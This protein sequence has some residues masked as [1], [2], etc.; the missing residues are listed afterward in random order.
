MSNTLDIAKNLKQVTKS[1]TDLEAQYGRPPG[2]VSLLAVSKTKPVSAIQDAINAGQRQFGE[3]YL[4]E[5]IEKIHALKKEACQ[6]HFIGGIQSRKTQLIAEHFDWV[7]SVDRVKLINRLAT[8]R[9][10]QLQA[11]NVCLQV[12]LDHE[13]SKS[14]ALETDLAELANACN[15]HKSLRLRGLMA[16][17]APRTQLEE[18]REPFAR[19]AAM[20]NSLRKDHPSLDTLSMG[21]SSDLPAAIAEGATIVRVGTAIF[22]QR[23]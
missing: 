23:N 14:G 20:F 21:M 17:P 11:L 3:N 19:L 18:Q 12:N 13:Q 4:D 10:T 22:G 8:Q 1:I 5:A 6:W 2:S 9:P 7:H 15:Q 16:I